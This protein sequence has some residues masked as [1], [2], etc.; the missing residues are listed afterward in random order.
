MNQELIK[1]IETVAA[2]CVLQAAKRRGGMRHMYLVM[3]AQL[4]EDQ[5]ALMSAQPS[6][7]EGRD[8]G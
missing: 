8:E 7:V 4:R 1:A 2:H 5:A 6:D 3:E